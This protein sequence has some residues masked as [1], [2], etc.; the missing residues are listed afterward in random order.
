[1]EKNCANCCWS[2]LNLRPNTNRI[3]EI[4]PGDLVC[5]QDPDPELWEPTQADFVC[6]CWLKAQKSLIEQ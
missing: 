4:D 6:G 1:M 5:T 2:I 3:A